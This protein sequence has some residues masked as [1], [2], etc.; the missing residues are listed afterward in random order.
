M[1][2]GLPPSERV[3]LLRQEFAH[4]DLNH[5]MQLSRE[6]LFQALDA[7][8]RNSLFQFQIFSFSIFYFSL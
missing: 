1:T 3:R 5:D 6:E 2:A 7:M 4:L 8:V